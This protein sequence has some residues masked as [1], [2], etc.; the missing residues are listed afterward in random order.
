ME[1]V[2]QRKRFYTK[3]EVILLIS[4]DFFNT[5][6]IPLP[7]AIIRLRD[8]DE[9]EGGRGGNVHSDCV[10]T[11]DEYVKYDHF[12]I[13]R[14]QLVKMIRSRYDFI[15]VWDGE[16]DPYPSLFLRKRKMQPHQLPNPNPDVVVSKEEFYRDRYRELCWYELFPE[17]YPPDEPR[18][19][20]MKDDHVFMN[21]WN[22]KQ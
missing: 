22:N 16:D 5:E 3:Y 20:N 13:P 4:D 19:P 17:L 11:V 12:H 21:F 14:P 2:D 7:Q 10:M 6:E 1:Q 15:I 18:A 9:E 8:D